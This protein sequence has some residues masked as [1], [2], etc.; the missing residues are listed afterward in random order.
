MAHCDSSITA[1][2]AFGQSLTTKTS[3]TRLVQ[4]DFFAFQHTVTSACEVSLRVACIVAAA[5]E[6]RANSSQLGF[7]CMS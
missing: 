4:T 5:S 6:S 1:P 3:F 2:T 7:N